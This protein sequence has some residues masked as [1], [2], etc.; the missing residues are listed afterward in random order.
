MKIGGY[1]FLGNSDEIFEKFFSNPKILDEQFEYDGSDVY[2]SILG[3]AY[4]AKN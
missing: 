2:G 3:D 4:G 1:N